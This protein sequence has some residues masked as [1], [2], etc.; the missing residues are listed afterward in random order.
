MKKEKR[1]KALINNKIIDYDLCA[2][3]R[4]AYENMQDVEYI[5]SGVI[6][7][8]GEDEARPQWHIEART[9]YYFWID[10]DIERKE[11]WEN[12]KKKSVF[13]VDSGAYVEEKKG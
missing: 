5:E 9:I 4:S 12:R 6:Y 1:Y 7:C 10:K 11:R 13:Y 3:D 2:E 8:V